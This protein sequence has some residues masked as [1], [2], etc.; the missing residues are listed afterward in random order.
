MCRLKESDIPLTTLKLFL[1]LCSQCWP[2]L[3]GRPLD[4]ST[5]RAVT[6]PGTGL[7]QLRPK[8][9]VDML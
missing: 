6:S 1:W 5:P 9:S 8:N 3:D 7:P 2:C 4:W